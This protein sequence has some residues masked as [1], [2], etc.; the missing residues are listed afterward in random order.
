VQDYTSKF[1]KQA[2]RLGIYLEDPRVVVKYLGGLF[3]DIQRQL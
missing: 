2:I 1:R 3:N